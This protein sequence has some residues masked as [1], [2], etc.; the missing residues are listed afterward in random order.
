MGS[1]RR[2]CQGR[3]LSPGCASSHS[4]RGQAGLLA[5]PPLAS[6]PCWSVWSVL[7]PCAWHC[8]LRARVPH[9]PCNLHRL[10]EAQLQA[11][12]REHEAEVEALR[13][14]V[15]ALKEDLDR[16]QQTF[17]QTLLLSPEAQL[18]FGVRQELTR[19]TNDNLVSALPEGHTLRAVGPP[20]PFA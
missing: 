15:E 13:A 14:Q 19:L 4:R 11:Q 16:Q 3:G 8:L 6:F 7:P 5:N 12:G 9:P 20:W 18:E 10:L 1:T 17:C 2:G